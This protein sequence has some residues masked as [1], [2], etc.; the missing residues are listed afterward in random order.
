METIELKK[1]K[2]GDYFK[3]PNCNVIYVKGDYER[4]LKKFSCHKFDNVNTERFFK[5][6]KKVIEN[7]E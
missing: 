7:F 5:G 2:K 3:V 4:S 1:L 6:D